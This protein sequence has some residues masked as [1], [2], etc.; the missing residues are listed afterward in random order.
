ML[1]YL[2]ILG[3]CLQPV[4][5]KKK[6]PKK[7][8]PPKENT[9]EIIDSNDSDWE[10]DMDADIAAPNEY[11]N[12]AAAADAA[13]ITNATSSTAEKGGSKI[14]NIAVGLTVVTAGTLA[15]AAGV[16]PEARK[17]IVGVFTSIR[18]KIPFL[19]KKAA[20]DA[21]A[22]E[23]EAAK[24]A[25]GEIEE[26][27]KKEL[28]LDE[29][30]VK[31]VVR[32]VTDPK[33]AA[34]DPTILGSVDSII[35]QFNRRKI[36]AQADLNNQLLAVTKLIENDDS[37]RKAIN[38]AL[39]K[40]QPKSTENFLTIIARN[41]GDSEANKTTKDALL[42][43]ADN[44]SKKYVTQI[45]DR[46]SKDRNRYN[47]FINKM[48]Q[49]N[50]GLKDFKPSNVAAWNKANAYRL[51]REALAFSNQVPDNINALKTT[52]KNSLELL[53]ADTITIGG[54]TYTKATLQNALES[55]NNMKEL[56]QLGRGMAKQIQS[57]NPNIASEANLMILM[58]RKMSIDKLLSNRDDL[59][60]SLL[61]Q[62][63][64]KEQEDIK[65]LANA[66]TSGNP[67]EII[68]HLLNKNSL[69]AGIGHWIANR[70]ESR[71]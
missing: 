63:V 47:T 11:L 25:L 19:G 64:M 8:K 71:L 36:R 3:L 39:L 70:A 49:K 2:L 66:Y 23:A 33:E 51:H 32:A 38:T 59:E 29:Q 31:V 12:Q 53:G 21:A 37:V 65:I 69:T 56:K 42:A 55:S 4:A 7:R 18:D 43:L 54:N 68:I 46:L 15:I 14:V 1:K 60:Q 52:L 57:E 67:E 22:Q 50:P 24:A 28:N 16:S 9:E 27:L 35:K 34:A 48:I 41:L 26:G 13:S 58:A 30:D 45:V 5:C 6:T 62:T 44:Y 40:E 17:K 61:A 10:A 20:D